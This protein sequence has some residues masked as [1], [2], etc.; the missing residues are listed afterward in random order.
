MRL[1]RWDN[2]KKRKGLKN[3]VYPK[4][5][6]WMMPTT[7]HDASDQALCRFVGIFRATGK[8]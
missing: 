3:I 4:Q 5:F 1:G 6:I 2:I 7:M 8:L